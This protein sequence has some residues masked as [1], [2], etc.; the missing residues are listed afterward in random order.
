MEL[1]F[2]AF[3]FIIT[4]AAVVNG[5]KDRFGNY[6]TVAQAVH[7]GNP[8]RLY[9]GVRSKQVYNSG[10]K[11]TVSAVVSTGFIRRQG[12]VVNVIIP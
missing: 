7:V 2:R 9:F 4:L 10:N 3:A 12:I 11:C 5:L 6:I 8:I 1:D